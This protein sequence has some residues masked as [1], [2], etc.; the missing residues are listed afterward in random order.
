M[1]RCGNWRRRYAPRASSARVRRPTSRRRSAGRLQWVAE[2]GTAVS[3]RASSSRVSTRASW[4]WHGPSRPRESSGP[5]STW[6]RSSAK[7]TRL[8][9]SGNAVSR[10]NVDQAQSNRD[11]AEADLQVARALLAQ[12][13][14][15]LG[16]SRLTAPF[17]GVVSDRVRRAGEEVARG[18]VIARIV[19]PDELEIRLFV[20]LRHI[21]AIQPGHVVEVTADAA[22]VH[23]DG[24]HHRARGRPAH[25][26]VR[27]PGQGASR[28]RP[29]RGGQHRA[30]SPAARRAAAA[31]LGAARRADHPRRGPLHRAASTASSGP[32]AC[33]SRRAWPTVTGLRSTGRC[34]RATASSC[35]GGES[36]RGNEKL[37]IV[38]V[39]EQETRRAELD[40][41]ASRGA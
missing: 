26:V 33:P 38:G 41:R 18:E 27:G 24:Q 9:A 3:R 23:G 28:R 15:Q 32:S 31:A 19:N 7:S 37:D 16:R 29:A 13:D 11:L 30:G 20:P 39:L 5:R 8:R 25:A 6:W 22:R 1:P 4:R 14:D 36:L 17:A 34:G 12:T 21:R 2:P 35:A 40:A 10:F